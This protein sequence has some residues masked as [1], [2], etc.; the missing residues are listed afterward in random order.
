MKVE[1]LVSRRTS[2]R[3][4]STKNKIFLNLLLKLLG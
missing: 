1:L 4:S 3:E 2:A